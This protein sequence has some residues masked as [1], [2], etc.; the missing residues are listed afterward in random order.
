MDSNVIIGDRLRTMRKE[1][2][3]SQEEIARL[4]GLRQSAYGK[5]E[6]GENTLSVEHCQKLAREF[7][8]TLEFV[9]SGIRPEA[10]DFARKTGLDQRTIDALADDPVFSATVNALVRHRKT[11]TQAVC[12]GA[13]AV[14]DTE[15]KHLGEEYSDMG[16]YSTMLDFVCYQASR[17]FEDIYK[18]I[19]L[20]PSVVR[21]VCG[22]DEA[23][24]SWEQNTTAR[25]MLS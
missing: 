14:H 18:S 3:K 19:C 25:E 1:A 7:G 23:S 20:E 21:A 24:R 10:V 5:I 2:R 6:R 13:Q 22:D 11:I 9:Y 15:E 12:A 4:L 8:V 17:R 16:D